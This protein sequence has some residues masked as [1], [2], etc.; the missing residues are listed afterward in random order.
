MKFAK[1]L[2]IY[3]IFFTLAACSPST[4]TPQLALTTTATFIPSKATAPSPT[5]SATP[6]PLP[7]P[8][9]PVTVGTPFP[10]PQATINSSNLTQLERLIYNPI[11]DD[12]CWEMIPSINGKEITVL[13]STSLRLYDSQTLN[14]ISI[15]HDEHLWGDGKTR[16]QNVISADNNYLAIIKN[17]QVDVWDIR[18]GTLAYT[19]DIKVMPSHIRSISFSPNGKSLLLN[20]HFVGDQTG[21][22]R[23]TFLWSMTNGSLLYNNLDSKV[24]AFSP[25]GNILAA[26]NWNRLNLVNSSTGQILSTLD[27]PIGLSQLAFSSDGNVLVAVYDKSIWFWQIDSGQVIKKFAGK[28]GINSQSFDKV[29]FSPDSH[30][31]F[32]RTH[33]TKTLRVLDIEKGTTWMNLKYQIK[34][35]F[36]SDS[37]R[38]ATTS[39]QQI[40]FPYWTYHIMIWDFTKGTLLKKHESSYLVDMIFSPDGSTLWVTEQNEGNYKTR[41]FNTVDGSEI[42]SIENEIKG[43]FVGYSLMNL[44]LITTIKHGDLSLRNANDGSVIHELPVRRIIAMPGNKILTTLSYSSNGPE[45]TLWGILP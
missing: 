2:L 12:S 43:F 44:S 45:I 23:E 33:D 19:F 35:I 38:L 41:V 40:N 31:F 1:Q 30:Y 18:K 39:A 28:N 10:E 26:G 21:G 16:Y 14:Q 4:T 42:E 3:S 24:T 5:T 15:T 17:T 6:S 34:P 11:D 20:A 13:C 22:Y 9:Y 27:G 25:D 29:F 37:T 7:E 36:S 32:V 8:V